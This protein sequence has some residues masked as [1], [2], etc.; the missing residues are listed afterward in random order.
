MSAEE[1]LRILGIM[2]GAGYDEIEAQYQELEG[3]Y[4]GDE[5][6]LEAIESARATAVENILRARL[7]GSKQAAY[8]GRIAKEDKP[9]P[10][11][12]P[13]WV[14]VNDFRKKILALPSPKYALQVFSILGGLSLAAWMSPTQAGGFLMLNTVSAAG[15]MY[16]RGETEAARDDTGQIG[17]IKPAKPKPLA[18]TIAIVGA[19]WLWGYFKAK[20]LGPARGM[21]IAMRTSLISAALVLPVLFIKVHPL[22]E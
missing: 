13:V 3:K 10:K 17:E 19:C 21:E 2:E 16:N 18:L 5:A 15:F 20:A 7:E 22:F 1:A 8:D 9:K 14:H 6:K 11:K 4:A 12:T